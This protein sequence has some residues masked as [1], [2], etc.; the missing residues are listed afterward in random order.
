MEVSSNEFFRPW[1]LK[2]PKTSDLKNGNDS[3]ITDFNFLSPKKKGG[4]GGDI[5]KTPL[6]VS[7]WTH[8][9]LGIKS[10]II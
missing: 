3:F 7:E 8:V 9:L 2:L 1:S 10:R 5:K 6:L 4:G